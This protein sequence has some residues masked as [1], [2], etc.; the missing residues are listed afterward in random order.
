M[1]VLQIK[2]QAESTI[3]S[4]VLPQPRVPP[5]KPQVTKRDGEEGL[6]RGQPHQRQLFKAK[7]HT[8]SSLGPQIQDKLWAN[9][10]VLFSFLS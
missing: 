4:S 1:K 8:A 3:P 6:S 2:L 9:F 5:T 10:W 7:F